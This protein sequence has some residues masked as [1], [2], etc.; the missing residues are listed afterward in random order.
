MALVPFAVPYFLSHP[1]AAGTHLWQLPGEVFADVACLIAYRVTHW[2]V[3]A[4]VQ[5]AILVVLAL[6]AAEQQTFGLVAMNQYNHS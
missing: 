1:E 3:S 6:S 5:A 4:L 2:S